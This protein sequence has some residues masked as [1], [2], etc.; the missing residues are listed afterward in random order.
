MPL[1]AKNGKWEYRFQVA[2]ATISKVTDWEAT[3]LNRKRAEQAEVKARAEIVAGIQPQRRQ[4]Q[5]GFID[6]VEEFLQAAA[7]QHSEH[8]NTVKR[9]ASSMASL[10]V[11]FGR[12]LVSSIRKP[13]IERYKVHRIA[14]HQV[15]PITLRHDLDALSKFFGWAISMELCSSNPMQGIE[16]PST[17]NAIRMCVLALGDQMAYEATALSRS[18]DLHDLTLIMAE[19]GCRPEEVLELQREDVDLERG[20]ISIRKGKSKAARRVLRI[21]GRTRGV[22]ARRIAENPMAA[23]IRPRDLAR[24][25]KFTAAR[26]RFVFPSRRISKACT[27]HATLTGLANAHNDVL[28]QMA[29]RGVRL[30]CVIYDFRH[31]FATRAA[32]C[33]MPLG[34]LAAILGHSSIRMVTKYVHPTQAHQETEMARFDA[35]MAELWASS[36]PVVGQQ[37]N[38]KG[39][40]RPN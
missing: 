13:D 9:L 7:V 22:L 3:E 5:R 18:I 38:E 8:P 14:V 21:T 35:R 15:K 20:T 30:D 6:V 12:Q 10:K 31:T 24:A 26:A 16:K 23:P 36:R 2:G 32:E 1:R 4:R 40:S 37:E 25:Q 34:T 17:D 19:Q 29:K 11:H 39:G 28:E 33:G 27:G